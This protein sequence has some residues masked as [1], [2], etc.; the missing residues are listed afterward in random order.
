[1]N[2]YS[3][4]DLYNTYSALQTID[5]FKPLV[6]HVMMDASTCSVWSSHIEKVCDTLPSP[7]SCV[8]GIGS[9]AHVSFNVRF[10]YTP[11]LCKHIL[12]DKFLIMRPEKKN[13]IPKYISAT[14]IL[15]NWY[16]LLLTHLTNFL[17]SVLD[18]TSSGLNCK[19][20]VPD[21]N[22]DYYYQQCFNSTYKS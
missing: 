3:A 16:N 18:Q 2:T 11:Y 8:Y 12:S 20:T 14:G 19:D 22:I 7:L 4:Y 15:P 21:R 6:I 1:M 13:L 5:F 9:E 10:I 17:T